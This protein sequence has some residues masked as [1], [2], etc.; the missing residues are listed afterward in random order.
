MN[1]QHIQFLQL[2]NGDVQ[3]VVPRWQ[4][5]YRWGQSDI[6]RLVEDLLTIAVAGPDAM[7][8]GGTLLTF[9]EPGPPGVMSTIRV[10]DGQQRLT[11]VSI[12]LACI[13]AELGPEGRCGDWT[14]KII[15]DRRLTNPDMSPDKR[16]KLRLQN[17]DDEEYRLGLEGNPTGAG[18]V[19]QA[20]RIARRLVARHGVP[21][22]LT[23]LE[24]LQVVSIGL[25]DKEDPQQ[26]FESLNAT[27]RPLTESEKVKNWL[28]IGLPD[29]EQRD[30]HDNYW[31][32]IERTLGAKHTTEPTDTFLRDVLRWRT[33][34]IH[35]LDRVY[36]G[37]RRWAVRQG[38]GADR[39][40]LCR[41][42][43]R[44]AGLYGILTGTAGAHSDPKIERELRHLREMG[45][46][47]HRPLTLR[48]L[49]DASDDGGLGAT[50]DGLA[51]AAGI[52]TWTTRLWLADRPTAGMNKA[53]VELAHG[54][55]PGANEDFAEHW[56]GRIQ[57]LRNT[58]VGVPSDEAV[59]EGI[60]TRK[61]YGGSATRSS[62][63]VLCA[64][65]E[66][67]QR[68]EAPARTPL[69]I[70]HVMPQK[71]TDDWRVA[72]GEEAEEKHGR[73]RD[74]LANL[75]LSGDATNSGMGA[76]TF[77][78]KRAVYRNSSIGM[79]RRLAD[80]SE[81]NEEAL[82][83]RAEDLTR[84]ALTRWPW[85]EAPTAARVAPERSSGLWTNPLNSS[86]DR[87]G[88]HVGNPELLWLYIRA[89]ESRASPARAARIRQ[90]SWRIRDQMGDQELGENLEKNSENGMTV[91]VRR[92]WT[93]DDEDEWP[94]AA[95]WIKEQFERLRAILADAPGGEEDGK[96][97]G[98]PRPTLSEPAS[99]EVSVAR[100]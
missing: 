55:G 77:D 30:L 8:Y 21:R 7:H 15:R 75:T 27:G 98:D 92:Q 39:P 32:R 58:R 29:E 42:L 65:M 6:E 62:F 14:A 81:W 84:R 97:V 51:R 4:R 99:A 16:R 26:I 33:G 76:G 57:R 85:R 82:E 50:D 17:G 12:L 90:Y 80:E 83:R 72:L 88:F 3:Y 95:E 49:Y 22:L 61:A 20:W 37:I 28:L 43:A 89:G 53:V 41:E 87:I 60:R 13:A 36:E 59:G 54:P 31:L 1:A 46:D 66:A 64:M 38:H 91:S 23:G 63:A 19:A 93:R 86:G 48:L 2:L 100:T 69:T 45:I 34:A 40:A 52:A 94:D 47:I 68:E 25:G 67:E 73:Y 96:A 10:V 70:E 71:L 44:L 5:R 11:T 24:R 74:R 35:G 56:L 78:A 79:T 18:A 9:R